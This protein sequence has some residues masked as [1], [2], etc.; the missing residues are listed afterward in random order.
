MLNI[1]TPTLPTLTPGTEGMDQIVRVDLPDRVDLLG[2]ND[3]A[4][5]AGGNDSADGGSGNDTINGGNGD[6]LLSG[7][8]GNDT[9]LG[10]ANRDVLVGGSNIDNLSGGTENDELFGGFAPD[11]VNGDAGNDLVAGESGG[12]NLNGGAGIDTLSYG[13]SSVAVNV[14]LLTN[15]ASGGDAAGDT[16]QQFENV[17]GSIANDTLVGNNGAN[18]IDGT[19]GGDTLAGAGGN[20]L[21][22]GGRG[23]DAM[24]GGTGI[25]TVSY[26]TSPLGVF[27]NLASNASDG[28]AGG[29]FIQNVENVI[30]S[31]FG[32]TLIGN[33]SVN[34]LQGGGGHDSLG[35]GDV[36][37]GADT[38]IGGT[39]DD[40]YIVTAVGTTVVEGAGEGDM[41]QVASNI[42]IAL[43]ANVE[44]LLLFG[45]ANVSGTGNSLANVIFGNTGHNILN[46]LVGAD[47]MTGDIGNDTY[48][49]DNAGDVVTENGGEGTDTVQQSIST[50]A[51]LAA[52]VENVVLLG[53]GNIVVRGNALVNGITGNSGNNIMFASAGLDVMRGGLG[54]DLMEVDDT[55]DVVVEFAG[56]GR[57]TIFSFVNYTLPNNV[58][59]LQLGY[60]GLPRTATG[61]ALANRM[62]GTTS[63]ETFDGKA[64]ADTM[65]GDYG[66]DFYYVDNAGDVVT[67]LADQASTRS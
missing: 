25:D 28:D 11:T 27:V 67:E 62:T 42:S 59:D 10:G 5:L 16:I 1:S 47:L 49:V 55:G 48:F 3:N 34:V 53:T 13:G 18:T 7:G 41:D 30:G 54:D 36:A 2:G 43:A 65:I 61:N 4:V 12:D 29:D 45:S 9:L 19:A 52:N 26:T 17:I 21:L 31:Q 33:A 15:V 20:D 6:D 38:M 60:V 56:Q 32:D 57:D 37:G 64:G 40:A 63:Q 24:D 46:G 51:E 50:N 66:D 22:I 35:D 14:N 44:R 58:E 8:L 39:G 23:A